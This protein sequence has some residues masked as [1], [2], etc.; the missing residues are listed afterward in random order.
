MRGY[1]TKNFCDLLVHYG[2]PDLYVSEFLRI[3]ETAIVTSDFKGLLLH[4][5]SHRP[6]SL[7]LMG[8]SP[9]AFIKILKELEGLPFQEINLNFGCPMPKIRKKGV[10]GGL[11]E[12]LDTLFQCASAVIQ[13]SP[14]PVSIKTRIGF[15]SFS[16]FP[17]ILECLSSLSL[18]K[19]FLHVRTVKGLYSEPV[20][21]SAISQA[22]SVLNYPIFV[23]GDIQSAQEA[24]IIAQTTGAD[25]VMIGRAVIHN[26]W[27]FQQ[28]DQL[29][30]GEPLF[31]PTFENYQ[32]Y[33][34]QLIQMYDLSS[35]PESRAVASLK[36]YLIPIVTHHFHSEP[37]VEAAKHATS[38]NEIYNI[39]NEMSK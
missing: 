27:I 7:Q 28:I 20:Q 25:G 18:S 3:H 11:L 19:L 33:I 17:A 22:K 37:L 8:N 29:H 39:C 38:F 26:P 30:A 9:T 35:L 21:Y 10:G 34:T 6:I 5:R 16:E 32:N 13:N 12:D 36:K 31:Q 1:T 15:Q 14:W 2:E 24:L 4:R 23:N